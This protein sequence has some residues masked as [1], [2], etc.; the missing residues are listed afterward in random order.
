MINHKTSQPLTAFPMGDISGKVWSTLITTQQVGIYPKSS[1]DFA[2]Y[3]TSSPTP[4]YWCLPQLIGLEG[5]QYITLP[6]HETPMYW[7]MGRILVVQGII[8][9]GM[10]KLLQP[11]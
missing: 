2:I 9:C 4:I 11:S 3:G 5:L 8:S 7:R 1:F 10:R 6:E